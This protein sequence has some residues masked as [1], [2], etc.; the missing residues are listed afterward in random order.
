M[1]PFTSRGVAPG[2]E[3]FSL[4]WAPGNLLVYE[5]YL[6]PTRIDHTRRAYDILDL[7]SELGGVLNIVTTLAG[8]LIY[9]ISE[10]S[11]IVRALQNLYLAKT[12]NSK[13]FRRSKLRNAKKYEFQTSR[14]LLPNGINLHKLNVEINV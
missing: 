9:S 1:F 12:D 11:F 4:Q 13:I 10:H 7:I 5:I 8:L 2:G 3:G 6:N 14:H